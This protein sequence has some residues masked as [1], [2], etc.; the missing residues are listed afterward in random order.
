VISL[1]QMRSEKRAL[2]P[3][4]LDGMIATIDTLRDGSYPHAKRLY[5]MVRSEPRPAAAAF[6]TFLFSADGG[7]LLTEAGYLPTAPVN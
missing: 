4:A 3:L 5:V 1:G 2:K 6:L 7:R